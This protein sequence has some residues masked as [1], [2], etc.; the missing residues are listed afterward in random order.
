MTTKAGWTFMTSHAVLLIEVART[1]R[2]H[3]A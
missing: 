3:G 2:G 1:P